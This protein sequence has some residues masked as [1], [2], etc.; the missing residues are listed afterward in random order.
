MSTDI[1]VFQNQEFGEL[2]TIVKE[3][4]PWFAAVDVCKA[5]EIGNSRMAT[6]RLDADEKDDVSLTDA[7]GRNQDTSIVSESGLYSLVLGSRKP[8]AHA[9][10]RWVTHD[11]IPS[12]RKHGAYMTPETIEKALLNPDTIIQLATKLKEEQAKSRALEVTSQQQKQII[13]EME[14][15]AS[16]YDKVL[17]SPDPVLASVIAKDYGKS[18]MW[19]NKRLHDFGIQ[20]K[21][22]GT[23]LLY[24]KYAEQ[25]Y[26]KSYTHT[27]SDRL[28]MTH[29]TILTCWTQK[30]RLFI[31]D[32][33]KERGILPLMEQ[34]ERKSA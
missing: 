27:Y 14:P 30:G 10:K 26:T 3:G 5:L 19:L 1:Q 20:Y 28:G 4:E 12:I 17:A 32:L 22:D 33:L 11:V 16:Y 25:G 2:R 7:I 29:S 34:D 18:G 23:W 15:K 6:D 9:F 13:A 21:L 24:Q 8:Q 31:Y